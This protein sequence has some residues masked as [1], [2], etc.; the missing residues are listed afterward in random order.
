MYTEMLGEYIF[1]L[2]LSTLRNIDPVIIRNASKIDDYPVPFI[3][4]KRFAY[5]EDI[6]N[7]VL[8]LSSDRASYITGQI[9]APNGGRRTPI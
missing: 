4:M 3:P 7:L 8:F 1:F 6:A 9:I 5:P 2:Y